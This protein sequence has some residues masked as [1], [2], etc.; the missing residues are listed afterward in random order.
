MK[1]RAPPEV[2]CVDAREPVVS[3]RRDGP[4]TLGLL[5]RGRDVQG[6]GVLLVAITLG[7]EVLPLHER[8]TDLG[9]VP[10]RR[11]VQQRAL[12]LVLAIDEHPSY[13]FYERQRIIVPALPHG[14][15]PGGVAHARELGFDFSRGPFSSG[16]LGHP[17]SLGGGLRLLCGL[18]L[19]RIHNGLGSLGQR[20]LPRHFQ[21]STPMAIP[22]LQVG[23]TATLHEHGHQLPA[24]VHG[25]SS[26]QD[27]LAIAVR[28]ADCRG[29]QVQDS[30]DDPLKRS[31][32]GKMQ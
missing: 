30:L 29:V 28:V 11:E 22:P 13:L 19:P 17:G 25:G 16:L 26:V 4:A 27:R 14:V 31:G 21:R 3:G 5:A 24:A 20:P 1:R 10:G 23:Q 9:P 7:D 8:L 32:D 6:R 15:E 12:A 2:L 18:F